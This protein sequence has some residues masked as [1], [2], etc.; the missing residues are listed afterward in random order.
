V[1]A[2]YLAISMIT[3]WPTDMMETK[4]LPQIA[5]GRLGQ[6]REIAAFVAFL[7]SDDAVFVTGADLAINGSVRM[8]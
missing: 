1:P 7:C 2:G 8:R 6:P 5:V 4:N 3:P